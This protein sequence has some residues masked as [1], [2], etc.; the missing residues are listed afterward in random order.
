MIKIIHSEVQN[1]LIMDALT[2]INWN[3][4]VHACLFGCKYMP[5]CFAVIST[6]QH[7]QTKNIICFPSRQFLFENMKYSWWTDCYTEQ[8]RTNSLIFWYSLHVRKFSL[9]CIIL[10]LDDNF[11]W[12]MLLISQFYYHITQFAL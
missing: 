7:K 4:N 1:L 5:I 10:H 12:S 2:N 6:R 11:S 3:F 9:K 8:L